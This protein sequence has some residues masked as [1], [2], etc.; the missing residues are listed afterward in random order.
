MT[1]VKEAVSWSGPAVFVLFTL[2]RGG[3]PLQ[4]GVFDVVGLSPDEV[5]SFQ[6]SPDD[7]EMSAEIWEYD[8]VF[9]NVELNFHA[10]L[11]ECLWRASRRVGGISWLSFEGA[12]HFDHLFTEDIANQIYGYCVLGGAPVVVWDRE[13]LNIDH[14]N[15]VI[16]GLK[17]E[18][19]KVLRQGNLTE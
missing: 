4:S 16:G 18:A 1:S 19:G 5:E 2:G 6:M 3:S 14:W 11:R 10:Y 9:H 17:R 8:L 7:F 13:K 15:S 12:F